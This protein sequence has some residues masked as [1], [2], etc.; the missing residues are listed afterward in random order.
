[1]YSPGYFK[2]GEGIDIWSGEKID[3]EKINEKEYIIGHSMGAAV[4]VKLWFSN[5]DKK[6]IL[7]N[8][9]LEQGNILRSII[10]WIGYAWYEGVYKKNRLSLKFFPE[11]FRKFKKHSKENHWERIQKIPQE[12]ITI[13]HGE[14]DLYLC[15]RVAVDKLK[16][17]GLAVIEVEEAGHNWH[18]NFDRE[19]EKIIK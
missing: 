5:Q 12:K 17:I 2:L 14:K 8:P 13:L 19:I 7:I 18:E 11:N 9:F 1:M 15:G 10:R 16:E 6:L 3:Q 4:A